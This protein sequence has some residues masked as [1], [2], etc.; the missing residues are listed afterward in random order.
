M[1]KKGSY[2]LQPGENMKR[3]GL[4]LSEALTRFQ[5][6]VDGQRLHVARRSRLEA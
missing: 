3:P 1:E 2:F 4:Y 5:T 6:L